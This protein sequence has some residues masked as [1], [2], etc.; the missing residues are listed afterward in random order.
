MDGLD[1]WM[2][3]RNVKKIVDNQLFITNHMKSLFL[4]N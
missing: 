1:R 2:D 4:K 3:D